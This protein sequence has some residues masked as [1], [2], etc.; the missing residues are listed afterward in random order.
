MSKN[1]YNRILGVPH[2]HKHDASNTILSI[3]GDIIYSE[4]WERTTREK[5]SA[6]PQDRSDKHWCDEFP[7]HKNEYSTSVGY[8]PQEHFTFENSALRDLMQVEMAL[9]YDSESFDEYDHSKYPYKMHCEHHTAHHL[10]AY[11]TCPW[12]ETDKDFVGLCVDGFGDEIS[13]SVIDSNFNYTEKW[14]KESSLGNFYQLGTKILG[15]RPLHDDYTVMGLSS[16]GEPK[17]IDL[18]HDL[19]SRNWSSLVECGSYD[20]SKEILKQSP[21]PRSFSQDIAA[22]FQSFVE[23]KV[24][25][26][27]KRIRKKG[28]KLLYSGGVAQN[29]KINT[30]LTD[31]FDEI[32]IP[33]APNDSGLT[34]G[35]AAAGYYNL[36]GKRKLRWVDPYLGY[37]IDK[38]INPTQVVRYLLENKICGVANGPGEWGP[39]ALGNRSLLADV[40]YDIKDEVNNIKRRQYFRPFGASILS[41]YAPQYFSGPMNEYMQY[42]SQAKHDYD[43]V[44][45]VDGTSRIQLVPPNSK[46]IIRQILEEYYDKTCVPML[47]N[48]SLNIRG[49][50]MVRTDKDG[51][52][53]QQKYKVK[54]F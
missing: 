50:P 30:L 2:G 53:F 9:P 19:Y 7:I 28:S 1:Q 41:E 44:I 40:R 46:S 11:S 34:L 4:A 42:S 52:R 26:I 37:S 49:E 14:G 39:R 10:S 24:I 45:H 17:Y 22:S 31:M 13:V 16:Y 29:I 47:L 32:W 6:Y 27:A 23:C 33:P 25:E 36:T 21:D 54:V 51:Q 15:M 8:L 20:I 48:T 35:A 38:Q 5:H 43:S 12:P 18:L 3:D